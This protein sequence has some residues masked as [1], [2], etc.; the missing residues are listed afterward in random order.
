[1][2][3]EYEMETIFQRV[4]VE[5]T[6]D[7]LDAKVEELKRSSDDASIRTYSKAALERELRFILRKADV[8]D[9]IA[10]IETNRYFAHDFSLV[11]VPGT[12]EE[13]NDTGLIAL[14]IAALMDLGGKK[15]IVYFKQEKAGESWEYLLADGRR[16]EDSGNLKDAVSTFGRAVVLYPNNEHARFFRALVYFQLNEFAKAIIDFD[17]AYDIYLRKRGTMEAV[18]FETQLD[19]FYFMRGRA[20]L[21]NGDFRQAIEDLQRS[22]REAHGNPESVAPFLDEARRKL[23]EHKPTPAFL[24]HH[25]PHTEVSAVQSQVG[26]STV[27][28]LGTISGD[29][30]KD[31]WQLLKGKKVIVIFVDWNLSEAKKDYD[32]VFSELRTVGTNAGLPNF[33]FLRNGPCLLRFE[34]FRSEDLL[35][36]SYNDKIF[37]VRSIKDVKEVKLFNGSDADMLEFLYSNEDRSNNAPVYHESSWKYEGTRSSVAALTIFYLRAVNLCSRESIWFDPEF[38]EDI[39]T[40]KILSQ[41]ITPETIFLRFNHGIYNKLIQRGILPRDKPHL[42]LITEHKPIAPRIARPSRHSDP[43]PGDRTDPE[44]WAFTLMGIVVGGFSGCASSLIFNKYTFWSGVMYGGVLGTLWGYAVT[45]SDKVWAVF[46]AGAILG[47]LAGCSSCMFFDKYT[48]WSGLFVGALI[49]ATIGW[50]REKGYSKHTGR[51]TH[52]NQ[53]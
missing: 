26:Q 34:T 14:R 5:C 13:K 42:T 43:Q 48:L 32:L 8:S 12:D 45:R 21:E 53:E 22:M 7:E 31:K 19:F 49:G 41:P 25:R 6:K 27:Q 1:M 11:P 20:F 36:Y 50:L 47:G 30:I 40:Q 35:F 37:Y 23:S 16:L 52:E 24:N 9:E 46:F 39:Q 10:T 51:S 2:K 38:L 3:E 4:L 29:R 33:L 15:W 18:G 28:A 17:S 44:W